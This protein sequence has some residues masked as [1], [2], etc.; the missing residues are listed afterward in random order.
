MP[1]IETGDSS[2]IRMEG[3]DVKEIL[4]RVVIEEIHSLFTRINSAKLA[5]KAGEEAQ[6]NYVETINEIRSLSS[7]D[8]EFGEE[9]CKKALDQL[10]LIQAAELAFA[11]IDSCRAELADKYDIPVNLQAGA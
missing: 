3:I 1:G 8:S 2:L 11:V 5:I 6:E 9:I 4:N 10:T 7:D